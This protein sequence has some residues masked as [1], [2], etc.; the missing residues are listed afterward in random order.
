MEEIKKSYISVLTTDS[1]L[2]GA[3]VV[4]KCLQL[5]KTKYPYNVLITKNI[6]KNVI[7]ILHKNYISTIKVDLIVN[8]KL[9]IDHKRYMNFTKFN[10]FRLIQ[11][12]KIISIDLDMI[13]TENIDHL[14][15]KPH[16]SAVNAGGFIALNVADGRNSLSTRSAIK[17]AAASK[18]LFRRQKSLNG[19]LIVVEPSEQIFNDIIKLSRNPNIKSSGEQS[20]LHKYY[21]KLTWAKEK[22]LNLGYQYN[23]FVSYIPIAT[24]YLG[25]IA[26]DNINDI[27]EKSKSEKNI[28]I[29]HYAY[30]KP[31][32]KRI[33]NKY[34]DLWREIYNS[35]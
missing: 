10:I 29:F 4:N 33:N 34:H 2:P 22:K 14:F 5:T 26:I 24:K 11:F 1:Y 35:L 23:M 12:S 9:P 25:F 30:S 7:D 27:S 21:P 17:L 15:S 31:W 19:G 16:F 18:P 28:K 13:I 20:I 3:L 32:N 8:K 6:S